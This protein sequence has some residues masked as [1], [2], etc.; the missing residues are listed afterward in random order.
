MDTPSVFQHLFVKYESGRTIGLSEL[1][2]SDTVAKVKLLLGEKEGIP[3]DQQQ[4]IY[5]GSEMRDDETLSQCGVVDFRVSAPATGGDR[6]LHAAMLC[7]TLS[8]SVFED[9][10]VFSLRASAGGRVS[11]FQRFRN[12]STST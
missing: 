3:V 12:Q 6:L 7:V 10:G 9:D 5:S 8:S 4:L 2:R 1:N 11:L